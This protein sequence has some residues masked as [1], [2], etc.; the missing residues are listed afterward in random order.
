VG[1]DRV[2]R[3]ATGQVN[4]DSFTHGSSKQ[5]SEWFNHGRASGEPAYCDTFSPESL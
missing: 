3:R 1:D 2:Q 5:R 4:P